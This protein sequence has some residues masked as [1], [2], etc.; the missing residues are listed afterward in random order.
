MHKGY[1]NKLVPITFAAFALCILA[2]L[3]HKRYI[4]ESEAWWSP[5]SAC[6]SL[7]W[8]AIPGGRLPFVSVLFGW[9]PLLSC[10]SIKRSV[11]MSTQSRLAWLERFPL[12]FPCCQTPF[13]A[14]GFGLRMQQVREHYPLETCSKGCCSPRFLGW[15]HLQHCCSL[16]TSKG[17]GWKKK[18]YKLNDLFQTIFL[19]TRLTTVK[20]SVLSA[21][22]QRSYPNRVTKLY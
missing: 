3:A 21:K 2:S 11:R 12:V 19:C 9:A 20:S 14:E 15:K 17:S 6:T 1:S 16:S 8:A 4:M 13:P 7:L 22:G 5:F 10:L 18:Q